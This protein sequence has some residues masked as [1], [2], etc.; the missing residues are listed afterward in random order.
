MTLSTSWKSWLA[1]AGLLVAGT[2]AGLLLAGT[3]PS[4]AAGT[5]PATAQGVDDIVAAGEVRIGV[6]TGAPPFGTIDERGNPAGYDVDV[7]NLVAEYLGV[8]AKLVPLTPPARIP[9]LEAG[10]VDFL[11]ATLA[12]TPARARTVM[13]TMPYSAFRMVIAAPK[14]TTHRQDRRA[15]AASAS[16]STAAPARRRHS[17][18]S[19]SPTWRSSASRTT[20]P[21]PR[22]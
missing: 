21:S 16:A 13:F 5:A 6:L 1:G 19:R 10:K 7:A 14:G 18:R 20:R 15:L 4:T 17:P 9:A 12:P 11:V 22:R 3:A 2:A 8:T